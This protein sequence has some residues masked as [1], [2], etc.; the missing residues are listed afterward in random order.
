MMSLMSQIT[1]GFVLFEKA[2]GVDTPFTKGFPVSTDSV[3]GLANRL[4]ILAGN[5]DE[6]C[7]GSL[8]FGDGKA[9]SLLDP[10]QQLGQLGFG[11]IGPNFRHNE[12]LLV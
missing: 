9:F 7:H 1:K 8:V 6:F 5:G 12:Y 10:L 2:F 3:D 4:G 11:L